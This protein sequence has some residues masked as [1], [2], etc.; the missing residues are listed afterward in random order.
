MRQRDYAVAL[1]MLA[2]IEAAAGRPAEA[3]GH[4]REVE[5]VFAQLARAGRAT[6]LDADSTLKRARD[7]GERLCP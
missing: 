1:V 2:D 5:A 3:C 6:S 4:Y 7:A